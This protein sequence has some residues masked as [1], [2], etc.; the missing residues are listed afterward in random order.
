MKGYPRPC[1][2][3]GYIISV[4]FA[5]REDCDIL[6]I[7][8]NISTEVKI[9]ECPN[10]GLRFYVP[11]VSL[12]EYV[13]DTEPTCFGCGKLLS[14]DDD[15]VKVTTRTS[16]KPPE[17]APDPAY[18]YAEPRY[19]LYKQVKTAQPER[20]YF[21]YFCSRSCYYQF[22]KQNGLSKFNGTILDVYY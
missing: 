5:N 13:N 7:N 22:L 3:C 15:I 14:E 11:P 21:Y 16:Y 18:T 20:D 10:C 19:T 1:P 17:Y 8:T 9:I 2:R 12:E 4:P 6:A